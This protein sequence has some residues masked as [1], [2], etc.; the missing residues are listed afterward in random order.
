MRNFTI[1]IASFGFLAFAR[2]GMQVITP[3]GQDQLQIERLVARRFATEAL[4]KE[5]QLAGSQFGVRAYGFTTKWGELRSRAD[6]SAIADDL[7]LKSLADDPTVVSCESGNKSNCGLIGKSGLVTLSKP[8]IKADSA[9]VFVAV[10]FWVEP[11][12]RSMHFAVDRPNEY[13]EYSVVRTNG[14]WRIDKLLSVRRA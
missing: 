5:Q 10:W 1:A 3:T 9:T 6:A 12:E 7:G 4:G 11:S 2:S 14:S 13:Y 8:Q